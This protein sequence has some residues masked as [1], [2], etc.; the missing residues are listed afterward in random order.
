MGMKRTYFSCVLLAA[1]VAL[2]GCHANTQEAAHPVGSGIARGNVIANTDGARA[3][4]DRAYQMI[5]EGKYSAAEPALKEAVVFDPMYG[6]A[7][8]DLGLVYFRLNRLYDAAWEFEDAAKLMPKQPQPENNLGLVLEQAEQ[9]PEAIAAYT[10]AYHLEPSNPEYIGNL[11]RAHVRLG[12]KDDETRRLL[13][14]L[15]LRD[16]RPDWSDWA[17]VNLLRLRGSILE[18]PIITP[19]TQPAS[20]LR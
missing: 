15:V 14:E 18:G 8:N 11:A 13:Q 5:L 16:T 3:D 10:K 9:L 19:M 4:T 6:P 2:S 20:G 17:R 12:D 7:H 1:L